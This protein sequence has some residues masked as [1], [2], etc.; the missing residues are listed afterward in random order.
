MK[1]TFSKYIVLCIALWLLSEITKKVLHFDE[2]LYDN[3]A[4]KLTSSQ[5][6]SIFKMQEKWQWVGY[7]FFP[8]YVL[9]K[10]VIIASVA[11][12]GIFFFS[13]QTIYFK[14]VWDI[15]IK[16]E[17][18]FLLVPLSKIIWFYYFETNYTL[19]DI[20]NFYPLAAI[21]ITGYQGLEQWL[22]YPFQ[23]LNLFELAY[24]FYMAW[25]IG[26]ITNTNQDFGF[27][28]IGYSYVPMLVLWMAV[29]MFFTLN[30]S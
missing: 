19:E 18:I 21:N 23:T 4:E 2:L 5:I 29:V 6:N 16:A 28:I 20:Q 26:K 25:Q 24:I 3:L 11:Y 10:T 15:I 30:Y 27:K 13:K 22:V 12:V 14:Q 1:S 7:I 17:F 9:L 8:L